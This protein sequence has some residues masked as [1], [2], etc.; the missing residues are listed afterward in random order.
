MTSCCVRIPFSSNNSTKA[1][2]WRERRRNQSLSGACRQTVE[3]SPTRA[4]SFNAY[5]G[6][7]VRYVGAIQVRRCVYIRNRHVVRALSLGE[8]MCR[9]KQAT[10]F[11]SLLRLALDHRRKLLAHLG[12]FVVMFFPSSIFDLFFGHV[13]MIANAPP[14]TSSSILRKCEFAE[15]ATSK[16]TIPFYSGG[17]VFW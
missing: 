11:F 8:E 12:A 15:T 16:P 4:R 17:V 2:S 10:D 6:K 3:R 9:D 5:S 13:R 7:S 14:S 1:E